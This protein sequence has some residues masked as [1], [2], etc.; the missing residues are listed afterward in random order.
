MFFS[1]TNSK[2][3]YLLLSGTC[4]TFNFLGKR[5]GQKSS[6]YCAH[7]EQ[8]GDITDL[9]TRKEEKVIYS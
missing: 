4:L 9:V 8:H 5:Y 1:V 2:K 7:V 3:W 6:I